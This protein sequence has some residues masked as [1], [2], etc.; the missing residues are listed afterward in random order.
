MPLLAAKTWEGFKNIYQIQVLF[1]QIKFYFVNMA[2]IDQHLN[3]I[4]AP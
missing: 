2:I 3:M 1:Y 4:L